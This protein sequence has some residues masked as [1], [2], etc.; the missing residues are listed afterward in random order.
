VPLDKLTYTRGITSKEPQVIE[1][2]ISSDLTIKEFKRTCK[3][4]ACSLGY[5]NDSVVEHFGRDDESGNPNQ[6][7]LLFD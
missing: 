1:L 4:L 2:R 3:R 6:L 7:K 5:S